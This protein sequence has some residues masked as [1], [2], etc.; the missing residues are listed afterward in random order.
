M[1]NSPKTEPSAAPS[2]VCGGSILSDADKRRIRAEVELRREIERELDDGAVKTWSMW[3]FLNSTL[4]ITLIG[5]TIVTVA[6]LLVQH[7]WSN[8]EQE[9][10][11]HRARHDSK[12][13][14]LERCCMYFERDMMLFQALRAEEIFLYTG[15]TANK[16]GV[17]R[18]VVI[19][20]HEDA[21]VYFYQNCHP[22][23]LLSQ[24]TASFDGDQVHKDAEQLMNDVN[25][26]YEFQAPTSI[27]PADEAEYVKKL[28]TTMKPSFDDFQS[29]LKSM[30]GELKQ[31]DQ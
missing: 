17:P 9:L 31:D 7:Q 22:Q 8:R 26:I 20:N 1:Q 25:H 24:I 10:A 11:R 12:Q 3:R 5:G 2:S 16:Q 14:V 13:L 19:K 29:L 21:K 23:T 30:T 15:A 27:K 4:F 6:T 18:E 28:Q